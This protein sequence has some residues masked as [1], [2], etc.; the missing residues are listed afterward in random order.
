LSFCLPLYLLALLH[1]C[2]NL[3]HGPG[4]A[5]LGPEGFKTIH[6]TVF[7]IVFGTIFAVVS[8]LHFVFVDNCAAIIPCHGSLQVMLP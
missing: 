2:I 7:P 4:A 6:G 1:A 8:V 3:W 5:L